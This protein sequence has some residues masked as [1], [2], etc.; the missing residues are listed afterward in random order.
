MIEQFKR[1]LIIELLRCL[2]V[3]DN[4]ASRTL[5]IWLSMYRKMILQKSTVSF[6]F[7]FIFIVVVSFQYLYCVDA[8]ESL[9]YTDPNGKYSLRLPP[10][11]IP[12]APDPGEN[13]P[14]VLNLVSN[15][16]PS[17]AQIIINVVTSSDKNLNLTLDHIRICLWL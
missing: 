15:E 10:D 5:L 1:V 9:T 7:T 16:H 3:L 17:S 4:W 12:S 8:Q 14:L 6:C 2:G 13:N 11:I